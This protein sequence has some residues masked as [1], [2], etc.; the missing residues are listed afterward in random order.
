MKLSEIRLQVGGHDDR[1]PLAGLLAAE[2]ELSRMFS[3]SH[4][5]VSYC[6]DYGNRDTSPG[7]V[8]FEFPSPSGKNFDD[9]SEEHQL[10]LR[11]APKAIKTVFEKHFKKKFKV[12]EGD[13]WSDGSGGEGNWNQDFDVE[14]A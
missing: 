9:E 6:G 1:L 13:G 4:W 7:I 11:I 14:E 8:T 2:A 5:R 10:F 12:S 3:H